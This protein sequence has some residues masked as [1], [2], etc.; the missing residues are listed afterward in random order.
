MYMCYF[1]FFIINNKI[2]LRNNLISFNIK[3][4]RLTLKAT[5]ITSPPKQINAAKLLQ[6]VTNI[7]SLCVYKPLH[8]NKYIK[9][10]NNNN[11]HEIKTGMTTCLYNRSQKASLEAE[12]V[13]LPFPE[14]SLD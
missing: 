11:K 12:N 3:N 5:T 1:L 6:N 2:L 9:R 4:N 13:N 8:T 7:K 14:R 10:L